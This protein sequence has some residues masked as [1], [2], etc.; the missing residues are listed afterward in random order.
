MLLRF[1]EKKVY[2]KSKKKS[3]GWLNLALTRKDQ[4]GWNVAIGNFVREGALFMRKHDVAI[5]WANCR[6]A[7]YHFTAV[8]TVLHV[9]SY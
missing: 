4:S 3:E 7:F 1:T 2:W 5:K 9:V 6:L 8:N